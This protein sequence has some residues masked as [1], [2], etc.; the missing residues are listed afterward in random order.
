MN[1]VPDFGIPIYL[2]TILKSITSLLVDIAIIFVA[3][4]VVQALTVYIRKN[5]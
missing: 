3:F 2:F 4:K 1:I 5:S